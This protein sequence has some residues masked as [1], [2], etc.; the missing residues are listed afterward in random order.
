MKQYGIKNMKSKIGGGVLVL[1]T[2]ALL[3]GCAKKQEDTNLSEGMAYLEQ[4]EY[5]AA[6]DCF[7]AATLYNEDK[8][9]ILRG[10]GL[11]YMGLGDYAQ[12]ETALLASIA[13]SSGHLTELEYDTNFY[14][15]AAYMKQGKYADAEQIY[16]AII[17]LRKKDVDAYYLRACTFLRR[18]DYEPALADFEKAFS[19]EPENIAL[20]TDAYVEMQAAGFAE[21]GR[22]YLE[23]FMQSREGNLTDR[24]RGTICYYLGDYENARI[25]LDG[26]LNAND[27]G[28]SLLLGQTYEKLGDR[29][30]AAV[31]YQ[32]YL[33]ANAPD[34]A[35]YNSLGICLMR[36]EKYT[37]A[38]EAFEA[39]VAM[40]DTDY[41]QNLK[42]NLIVANEHLGNFAQ[43]KTLMQEYVQ[44]YPEDADA[45]REYEFLSTR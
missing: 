8:Q 29:N 36:Q 2:A 43:A 21:E 3:G 33:D 39:G 28:I 20:V 38:L 45:A 6:L 27:A 22:V 14:L 30:Y 4:Y 10:E 1:L 15:A 44:I 32:T 35:I 5:Q 12:A 25:Y 31:V 40:G 23:S 19:L 42:F 41:L 18:G 13:C 26:L 11:A 34:A 7:E 9:L 24:D 16:S 17:A 37:E